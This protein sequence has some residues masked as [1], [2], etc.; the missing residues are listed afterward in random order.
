M[1]HPTGMRRRRSPRE[2]RYCEVK[3]APEKVHRTALTTEPRAEFFKYAIALHKH[4]P[5]PICIFAVVGAV[6]FIAIERDRILNLVGHGVDAHAQFKMVQRLHYHPVKLRDGK[7]L[8]VD[9]LACAI[10]FLDV[11]LMIDKIEHNL[12]RGKASWDR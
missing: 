1:R 9:C 4:A 12:K 7:R 2:T 11:Q 6:I 8:E 5:E 3:A 10:A